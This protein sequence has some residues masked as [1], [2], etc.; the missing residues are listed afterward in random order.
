MTPLVPRGPHRAS[1]GPHGGRLATVMVAV[2]AL[3]LPVSVAAAAQTARGNPG[4]FSFI[5]RSRAGDPIARWDPCHRIGYRVNARLGGRGA[6]ADAREAVSRIARRTGLRFVYRGATRVVPGGRHGN[7]YPAGTRLVV[8]WAKPSRSRY[9]AGGGVAGMGGPR[10]T[11]AW[12]RR[13]RQTAMITRGFAVLNANLSLAGGFG[14]G[15]RSGWQGTRG[16][17]L[18]HEIG[19]AVGLGHAGRDV[20][21]IMHPQMTRKPAVWGA[22]DLRGLAKLGARGGCLS[23]RPPR[24]GLTGL[25]DLR[26]ITGPSTHSARLR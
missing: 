11:T 8:A 4:A 14:P 10:W 9:L 13:G 7:A 17:L 6:L 25:T 12:N 18:M 19:H 3:C 2:V 26:D 21:Q 1:R 15:P 23:T 5:S 16:Q 24:T 20:W 22:G